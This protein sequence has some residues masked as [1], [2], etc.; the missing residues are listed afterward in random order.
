MAVGDIYRVTAQWTGHGGQDIAQWVWH[1]R[2]A[3]GGDIAAATIAAAIVTNF[4]TAWD[5]IDGIVSADWTADT[6]EL[7]LWDAVLNQFDTIHTESP[8][9]NLDGT[10][11]GDNLPNQ[12]SLVV[13]F[14]TAVGRS[15]GKKF[16]FGVLDSLQLDE[17]F[18][19]TAV[20][21]AALFAADFDSA[22][23]ASG[24]TFNPGNFNSTTENF[25]PWSGTVEANVLV[26]SQDRRRR[27]IGL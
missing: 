10:G 25:T 5:N 17:S 26:G 1:Y 9:S 24:A 19:S 2:Q 3:T 13:K 18:L 16:I 8:L 4:Q 6:L 14:F 11:S 7:A 21:P 12:D 20:T 27:G 22:V 15:I 23:S